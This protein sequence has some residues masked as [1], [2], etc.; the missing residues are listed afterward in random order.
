M[1]PLGN[2]LIR[3][4]EASGPI[5]LADYM[6]ECLMHP[7]HGYYQ[8]ERVFGSDGDFITAPEVSQM[9][10][11]TLGLWLADRWMAM[12]RPNVV[13]L[14][15]LGPG[16]GTLMADILRACARV[17]GFQEAA[18]IH[19]VET[20]KQLRALQKQKV[21][22]ARWH[23]DLSTLPAGPALFVANEF[24]DA[25][26]IH[27]FEKRDGK[28]FERSVG[29]A[30]SELGFVL[31]QP[32][33]QFALVPQHLLAAQDGGVLEVCPAALSAT[34]SI[35]DHLKAH[36]GAALFI[37]YGYATSAPGDTFQALEKHDYTDPF[38]KPGKADLTAHVAF[39]RIAEAAAQAGVSPSGIGEQGT[40]LMGIGLGLRAQKLAEG[41]EAKE[42]G[43]ILGELKRLTA[44]DEMGTL[45]KVL[46]IQNPVLSPAP[47]LPPFTSA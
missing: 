31:T 33:S 41:M 4:I 30:D 14:I 7:R 29:A 43:R 23:D 39:D 26:P 1:T 6:A 24:F 12:G 3:R 47:G 38:K 21:P 9:F 11:E 5:S 17:P 15:E 42:Q 19:F 28:W 18:H 46:A 36:G 32:G 34:A 40:F 27:Q 2:I 10:G 25:L 8:R 13:H 37:D 35:A 16:R 45:F 20:S 22:T 44:P